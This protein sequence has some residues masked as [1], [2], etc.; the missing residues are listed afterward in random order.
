MEEIREINQIHI[1]FCNKNIHINISKEPGFAD[2][3]FKVISIHSIRINFPE[4]FSSDE[5]CISYTKLNGLVTET[6]L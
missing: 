2:V 1:M 4:V 3:W 5:S 6:V